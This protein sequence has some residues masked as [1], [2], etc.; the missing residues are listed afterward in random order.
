MVK[1]QILFCDFCQNEI[2]ET[3][4]HWT[5]KWSEDDTIEHC[6]YDCYHGKLSSK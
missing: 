2:D 5:V 4:Q 3:H 1:R 6:C